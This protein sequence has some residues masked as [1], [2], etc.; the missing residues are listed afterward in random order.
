[1]S[2][3]FKPAEW[4]G[5]L[6]SKSERV[7]TEVRVACPAKSDVLTAAKACCRVAVIPAEIRHDPED[8]ENFCFQRSVPAVL[9][10][11]YWG[12]KWVQ[13]RAVEIR[14]KADMGIADKRIKSLRRCGCGKQ[15]QATR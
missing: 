9:L 3:R 4:Q 7:E 12:R 1:M 13:L 14:A 10:T 8:R 15:K 5:D 2:I 6:R 11:T